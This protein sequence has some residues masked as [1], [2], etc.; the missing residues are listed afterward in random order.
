MKIKRIK[1][2]N[3][4][5]FEK[6]DLELKDFNVL[7]GANASGKSS[8]I[9]I[10]E[11]L[12][13]I[14]NYGLDN[15]ISMQGDIDYLRNVRIG[16]SKNISIEIEAE[17]SLG[18]LFENETEQRIILLSTTK[19][20]YSFSLCSY[21]RKSGFKVVKDR[22]I[23][24]FDIIDIKMNGKKNMSRER[25][26]IGELTR[27]NDKGN[28]K[29]TYKLPS[30]DPEIN[31]LLDS[32]FLPLRRTSYSEKLSQKQLLLETP[33][34]AAPFFLGNRIFAYTPVY[35]FDPRSARKAFPISGK[36]NLESDGSNIAIVM[37]DIIENKDKRQNFLSIIRDTLSFIEEVDYD[38][39]SDKS[40]ILRIKETFSKE[41]Y[42]PASI[43]SDGTINVIALIIALYF[44][45]QDLIII[46]EPERNLHPYLISKIVGMMKEQSCKKQIIA[47]THNSEFVKYIDLENLLLAS[48]DRGG[49]SEISRPSEKEEVKV[50]LQNEMGIEELFVQNLLE[51]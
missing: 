41:T 26:G 23:L 45:E 18:S 46:E 43:I 3:F 1:A 49:F 19:L 37:K 13:D 28:I 32:I 31:E 7:V 48:R 34:F 38:K 42:L 33:S 15:S 24:S 36:A 5:S 47:T 35:D 44:E 21:K 17:I 25:I 16:S 40:V 50:F 9:H 6:L 14:S 20:K 22:L 2:E 10:I 8:F 51:I 4:K 29:L 30:I 11:F 27:I 39:F 12:R